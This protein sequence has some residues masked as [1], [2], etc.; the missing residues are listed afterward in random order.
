MGRYTDIFPHILHLGLI[1]PI[2]SRA[3]LPSRLF[4]LDTVHVGESPIKVDNVGLFNLQNSYQR[5][6]SQ[7]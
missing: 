4:G 3:R 6:T 1:H 2:L 7:P 5:H